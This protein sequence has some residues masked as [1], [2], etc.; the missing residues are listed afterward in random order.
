MRPELRKRLLPKAVS[1]VRPFPIRQTVRTDRFLAY[2]KI[3]KT[4]Q[5]C[6]ESNRLF[7]ISS[8]A[9]HGHGIVSDGRRVL[10]LPQFRPGGALGHQAWG[11]DSDLLHALPPLV[12]PQTWKQTLF[13][14]QLRFSQ[15]KRRTVGR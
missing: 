2:G 14:R 13:Y 1:D 12:G 8:S 15:K 6:C 7:G 3:P 10:E 11:F 5:H 4:L 9:Y